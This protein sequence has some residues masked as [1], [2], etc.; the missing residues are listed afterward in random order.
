MYVSIKKRKYLYACEKCGK[1][2]IVSY[3]QHKGIK[4]G[5][6][7]NLC[8]RCSLLGRKHSEETKVK[9]SKARIGK[10]N[11]NYRGIKIT[12][13]CPVCKKEFDITRKAHYH[14][15][16]CSPKC[17]G[18]NKRT[19]YYHTGRRVH[20]M[21]RHMTAYNNWR[22]AIFVDDD[23]CGVCGKKADIIH[24][25]KGLAMIIEENS[26]T[27]DEEAI[28]CKELWNT[29]NGVALCNEHHLW[30]HGGIFNGGLV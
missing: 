11:S 14:H 4:K 29:S 15:V 7:N 23:N 3:S 8:R 16:C 21:I 6:Y 1:I 5:E 2:R 25:I 13:V 12:K 26:I 28:E 30:I 20:D 27:T 9:M 19:G 22:K 24:H 17:A 10:K 18:I